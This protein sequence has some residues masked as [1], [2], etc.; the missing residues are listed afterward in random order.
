MRAVLQRSVEDAGAQLL[1]DELH[2]GGN[3]PGEHF[4]DVIDLVERA[5]S[6]CAVGAYPELVIAT[7]VATPGLLV[8]KEDP[9]VG[10]DDEVELVGAAVVQGECLVADYD[11]LRRKLL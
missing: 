11:P 2:L 7:D 6:R 9:I 10:D 5:V 8:E 3:V 1:G 4:R